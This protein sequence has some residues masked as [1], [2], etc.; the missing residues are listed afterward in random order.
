MTEVGLTTRL[1]VLGFPIAHSLSPPMQRAGLRALGLPWAYAPFAVDPGQPQALE[2][3]LA[4]ARA[5][6]ILGLN[7]T[8]PHKQAALRLCRPD[9]SAARAGAVNT[10][11]FHPADAPHDPP[12]G[13][14]TDLHG[15][16]MLC[17]EAGR[18]LSSDLRVLLLGAGGAARGVLLAL[19]EAGVPLAAV[20]V[21]QRA[22]ASAELVIAG[23]RPRRAP[24]TAEALAPLLPEC[25]L[26]IDATPRGL[27]P[28]PVE[29]SHPELDLALLPARCTVLDLV[30]RSRTA[31][32]VAAAARGLAS[33]AGAPMLLHQGAASLSLWL[34]R[35]LPSDALA[36]M[37]AALTAAL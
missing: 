23:Q 8:M 11:H 6:G 17:A 34:E 25:D 4:G 7:V 18:P 13:A 28:G 16:Q 26:L 20:T 36:A 14:N 15:F 29:S 2:R 24:L 27:Q 5:L 33:S 3:A 35:P 32:T 30:V 10:L 37:R 31:L 22:E 9:A 12:R 19:W 1:G 21:A